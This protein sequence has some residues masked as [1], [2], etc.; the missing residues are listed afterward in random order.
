MKKFVPLTFVAVTAALL[1]F[2]NAAPAADLK[3]ATVDLRK[4]F[5]K[6][7][8]TVEST[9]GI[10]QEAADIDKRRKELVDDA[11][12]NEDEWRKLID[13]ANDQA[14]SSE[15]RDK[16]KKAAEQKYGELESDKEAI[17]E[18]DRVSTAQMHDKQQQRRDDI[19]KEIRQVL[20]AD[21][22]AAGYNMVLDVSGE[23]ANMVPFLLYTNGQTDM[24]DALIKE[25]N[26][27]AP[28]GALDALPSTTNSPKSSSS[29]TP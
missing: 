27:T 29:N 11:K 25:L 10:K 17:T 7:Y 24:T 4:V 6:Y 5:D 18:F 16:S 28:P 20:N 12:T 1:A 2:A 13:K 23:S 8:K 19:V 15:E 14:V 21:A 3:I 9:A 26:S 22:K